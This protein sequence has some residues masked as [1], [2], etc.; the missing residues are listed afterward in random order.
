V[1]QFLA[2]LALSGLTAVIA[3]A[4]AEALAQV[5]G[6]AII[7]SGEECD[8]PDA[9]ACPPV[10]ACNDDCVCQSFIRDHRC[11]VDPNSS[12]VTIITQALPLPPFPASGAIDILCGFED[13]NTGK[14]PCECKL[15]SLDPINIVGIGFICFTPG[16]P[17]APCDAGEIDCDGGNPLDVTMDSD[18]NIGACTG[19]PDCSSQCDAHCAGIGTTYSQFNSGCGGFCTGGVRDNLPCTDDSD[20]PGGSCTGKDGNPHGN[21]CLCDCA[22]VGGLAS[23]A[24]GLQCNLGANIDVEIASPCGDGD[25]L[26]AVG[27]RCIPL[28]TEQVTSQMHNT[29]N[30]PGK[31]FPVPAWTGTGAAIACS[32]LAGNVTSGL[33][34]V[35]S[36]NFFDSTIGDLQSQIVFSCGAGGV[37]CGNGL[38]EPGEEC[39]DG[40]TEDCDGCSATCTLEE[41]CACKGG[42]TDEDTLCDDEDPCKE[43]AN[44]LPLVISGFSGI[45]DECLCGDFDGDAFHSATDAAAINDCAAFISF[46]CVPERD[47]VAEPF[48]GFY[49]ATDADLVNRVAAFLDPAYTLKCGLRPEGTCGGDTGVYF[50]GSKRHPE[51][52]RL[53]AVAATKKPPRLTPRKG[54]GIRGARDRTRTGRGPLI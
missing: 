17:N 43:Y 34:V 24:G 45:P 25:V 19:N 40:N 30:S 49:S 39:D 38:V 16:D 37:E 41:A 53:Q 50:G 1:T 51:G 32:T 27:T 8:P 42:D 9:P 33:S 35:G 15:Q 7:E 5:C 13:P 12:T 21:V 44:T 48:D 6:N 31:D 23:G 26:I 52:T 29:N 18:H 2:V 4:P 28:T 20:C 54:S 10:E 47:E 22:E 3:L 36:A 14:S 11:E 46:A